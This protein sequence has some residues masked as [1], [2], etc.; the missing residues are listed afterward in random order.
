MVTALRA[1]ETLVGLSYWWGLSRMV[2]E[3]LRATPLTSIRYERR[4]TYEAS[5]ATWYRDWLDGTNGKRV[6]LSASDEGV[7]SVITNAVLNKKLEVHAWTM[8]Q[9]HTT[10]YGPKERKTLLFAMDI[11]DLS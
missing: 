2:P 1:C 4:A 8:T 10:L 5:V 7:N 6:L 11:T 9:R 3:Q